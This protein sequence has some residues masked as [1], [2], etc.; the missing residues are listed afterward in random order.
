MFSILGKAMD[1]AVNT[2]T[3][4]V[5]MAANAVDIVDGLVYG[6][7][8]LE[9]ICDLGIEVVSNMTQAEVVAWYKSVN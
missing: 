1:H 4:P 3:A 7:I 6:E 2:V 8:R 5:R 9:A